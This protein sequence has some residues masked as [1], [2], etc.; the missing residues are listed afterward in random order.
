MSLPCSFVCSV[1]PGAGAGG[2]EKRSVNKSTGRQFLLHEEGFLPTLKL[3][4]LPFCPPAPPSALLKTG[5]PQ[6]LKLIRCASHGGGTGTLA[7]VVPHSTISQNIFINGNSFLGRS[8]GVNSRHGIKKA[9]AKQSGSQ[10]IPLTN[11]SEFVS[12]CP[13]SIRIIV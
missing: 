11:K 9:G 12:A 13:I 8:R 4:A 10:R 6:R 1:V 2:G 3:A 7:P 5:F